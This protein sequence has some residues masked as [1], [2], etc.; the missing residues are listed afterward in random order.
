MPYVEFA[1]ENFGT[2]RCFCGSDW[3]VSMLA[4]NYTT[5]WQQLLSILN[6]LKVSIADLEKITTT[7]A[8]QFYQLQKQV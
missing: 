4:N 1:L 3:P 2:D 7:N 8:M 6:A 5:T